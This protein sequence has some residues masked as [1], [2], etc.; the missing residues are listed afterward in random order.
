M[1]KGGR[2]ETVQSGEREIYRC[3]FTKQCL[4]WA[5]NPSRDAS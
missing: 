1:L 5:G 4:I 2:K 3:C